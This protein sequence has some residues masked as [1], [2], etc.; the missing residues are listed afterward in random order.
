[1]PHTYNDGYNDNLTY[2]PM[3]TVIGLIAH[4]GLIY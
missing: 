3:A 1:M 4:T 2:G